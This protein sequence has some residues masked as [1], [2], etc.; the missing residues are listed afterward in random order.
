MNQ[1]TAW[2]LSVSSAAFLL[3]C[4]AAD[5]GGTATPVE[6]PPVQP[7]AEPETPPEASPE[8]GTEEST[9]PL[10]PGV[11]LG[12]DDDGQGTTDEPVP[13]IDPV[14]AAVCTAMGPAYAQAC[15]VNLPTIQIPLSEPRPPNSALF[16]GVTI[17]N[18]NG[19]EWFQM[20]PGG[21]TDPEAY[22][23]LFDENLASDMGMKCSVASA[24]RFAAVMVYPPEGLATL[25]AQSTWEGRFFNWNDD[26]SGPNAYWVNTESTLWA[27]ASH[28]IKWISLTHADGRCDLPT[29]SMLESAIVNCQ[30]TAQANGGSIQGCASSP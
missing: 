22:D 9:L 6:A 28:L 7:G 14:V 27:W 12:S 21:F 2:C 17:Y 1:W 8:P 13:A 23:A 24:L 10:L 3:A 4:G 26:Y 16:P 30:A 25:Q 18:M 29:L 20:W 19:W 11:D 15:D 5:E